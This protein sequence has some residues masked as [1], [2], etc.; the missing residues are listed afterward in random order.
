DPHND[1]VEHPELPIPRNLGA[2]AAL[3]ARY[4]GEVRFVDLYVGRI[5]DA[6]AQTGLAANTAVVI[7]ADHG[8]A[9]GEHRL[10]GQPVYYPGP[11]LYDELVRVPLIVSVPG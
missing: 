7:F 9:F 4:D 6:L 5:L 1:Y 10:N 8:E 11:T 2:T 3:R